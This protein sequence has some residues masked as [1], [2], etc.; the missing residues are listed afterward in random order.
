MLKLNSNDYFVFNALTSLRGSEEK[1]VFL[2]LFFHNNINIIISC[3]H[4]LIVFSPVPFAHHYVYLSALGTSWCL[5]V[6]PACLLLLAG[7]RTDLTPSW[8]HKSTVNQVF[9]AIISHITRVVDFIGLH[10]AFVD[11][12]LTG[13]EADFD[14][15]HVE[16]HNGSIPPHRLAKLECRRVEAN[17]VIEYI[18]P[19]GIGPEVNQEVEVFRAELQLLLTTE[20]DR[21]CLIKIESVAFVPA[22]WEVKR[23]S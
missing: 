18:N 11:A 16:V 12:D 20:P 9:K 21:N 17:L 19:H 15:I 6:E 3:L 23:C 2:R 10:E 8:L 5:H 4:F 7:V 13:F 22:H 14:L 1:F